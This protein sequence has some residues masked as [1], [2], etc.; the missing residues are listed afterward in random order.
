MYMERSVMNKKRCI[1]LKE[2]ERLYVHVKH[3]Q[4]GGQKSLA[5]EYRK[6]VEVW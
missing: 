2:W 4:T 6:I 3:C 5:I 1:A